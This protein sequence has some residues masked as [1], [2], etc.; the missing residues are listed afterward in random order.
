MEAWYD[1]KSLLRASPEHDYFKR[2]DS[3]IRRISKAG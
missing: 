3:E 1:V 2:A